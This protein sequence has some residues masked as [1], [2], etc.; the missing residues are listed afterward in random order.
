MVWAQRRSTTSAPSSAARASRSIAT[1]AHSLEMPAWRLLSTTTFGHCSSRSPT[2][3]ATTEADS[4]TRSGGTNPGGRPLG[5]GGAYAAVGPIALLHSS[6]R[7]VKHG[8][9]T[10]SPQQWRA[11]IWP[12]AVSGRAQA[13]SQTCRSLRERLRDGAVFGQQSLFGGAESDRGQG[14]AL[15]FWVSAAGRRQPATSSLVLAVAR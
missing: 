4:S 12:C 11:G 3:L 8:V 14:A 1:C 13:L 5:G 15:R 9:G 2:G 10:G 7:S 6:F